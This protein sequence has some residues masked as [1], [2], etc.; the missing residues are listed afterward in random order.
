MVKSQVAGRNA[1]TCVVTAWSTITITP[2]ITE[3]FDDTLQFRRL[4]KYR[5]TF[6]HGDMMSG[7][8]A[9][10]TNIAERTSHFFHRRWSPTHR[11]SLQLTTGYIY[12]L[13]GELQLDR[14]D[15]LMWA[16]IIALVLS[17][18]AA[19]IRLAFTL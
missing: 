7:I 5:P 15:Y 18:T 2:P 6:T 10:G 1:F 19:S 8:E 12:Q 13:L 17:L 16:I 9:N 11:S 3:R 14:I 4:G